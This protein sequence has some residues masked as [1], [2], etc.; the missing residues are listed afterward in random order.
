M[1]SQI[2]V[3]GELK[4]LVG[5]GENRSG[6]PAVRRLG[7]RQASK[8][9]RRVILPNP[10]QMLLAHQIR[11]RRQRGQAALSASARTPDDLPVVRVQ[12][13]L[14]VDGT[15]GG[16]PSRGRLSRG[17]HHRLASGS[18]Q[19]HHRQRQREWWGRVRSADGR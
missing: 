8:K 16:F 18:N 3:T 4:G 2:S 17:R 1:S 11:L 13:W 14:K 5:R 7:S 10:P 9:V 12:L 19:D 6:Q 15:R